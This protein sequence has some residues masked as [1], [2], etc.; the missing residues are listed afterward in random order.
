MITIYSSDATDFGNNGMGILQPTEATVSEIAG[1]MYEAEIVQPIMDDMR[2]TLVGRGCILKIPVPMR[3][4][5]A[6]QDDGGKTTVTR[7]IYRVRTNTGARLRLRAK[8]STSAKI[9]GRYKPGTL[10]IKLEDAATNWFKVS[11]KDGGAV[12]YMYTGYLTYV[13]SYTETVSNKPTS[14]DGVTPTPSRDQLFRIYSTEIDTDAGTITAKA[15]HIFYDL[16]GNIVNKTYEPEKDSAATAIKT[17]FDNALNSHDFTYHCTAEGEITGDYTRKNIV[18]C[19]LDTDEGI[20]AQC[21]GLLVRD[22]WDV[23]IIPNEERNTGVTIRRGKN[24]VGVTVTTDDS[25]IVTR[26]VPVGQNKDG[27]PLLLSGTKY[28]DSSHINEYPVIY[29]QEFEYSD[30]KSG[31]DDYKNDSAARKALKEAAQKEF[32]E[33]GVDLPSYSMEVDF[34]RLDEVD[35]YSDY[36]KLQSVFLNDTV[37]VIDD[38]VGIEAKLRV[39]EY[40]WDILA[41]R[42]NSVTLGDLE[43]VTQTIQSYNIGNGSISGTKLITGSVDGAKLRSLT[44]EYAKFSVAAVEQL[45]AD[46]IIALRADIRK[47]VAGSVTTDQLYADLATIAVAQLTTANIQNAN[48]DWASISTLTANI[49]TLV[50]ADIQSADIDWA[51]IENLNSVVANIA[52]AKIDNATITS[53]QISD[54]EAEVVKAIH[55]EI[56]VG[57]FTLAEVK[58]LLAN[59]LILEQGVADSMMI[60]NL[61]VTSANLLNATIGELVLQGT[62]GKYYR[63]TVGADGTISTEE[64]TVTDDEIS[65]GETSNGKQIV[66][67]TANIAALNSTTV[68]ASQAIIDTIYTDG[69]SAGKITAG[70]ALIASATIPALYTSSIEA[71]G[72]SLTFSANEKIQMLL[73]ANE[74]LQKWFTFDNDQ[75]LIIQKPAYTDSDGVTHAASI[76]RT[77][78]DETGYHIQRT[79]LTDYVASF[80]RDRL[81][82]DGTQ[83]GDIVARKT[84]NGG[85][86]WIDA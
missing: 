59:A 13:S 85:W 32:D 7:S 75:G 34:M 20:L 43:D 24:L 40:E 66:A 1:G 23:W 47:I 37:T 42:Y 67:T 27:D 74:E 21:K 86:A 81:I 26:I 70:E 69:L 31:S 22:N 55:A 49:A 50:K 82:V 58:N 77:I 79:D 8:P 3:E 16:R 80:A 17:V 51:S 76:W 61:A 62:D 29:S 5:P 83:I 2:W 39:T 63:V 14:A 84:S 46:A 12:G 48:I 41:G 4:N 73:G 72:N 57:D 38:L 52:Q 28:V 33:N 60:T 10:V 53:A 56:E 45:S 68:K 6:N 64:T 25:E 19:L 65:A 15:Y 9:L 11:I 44:V 30:I 71:I 78:T 54:L 18:E 35:G 36:G